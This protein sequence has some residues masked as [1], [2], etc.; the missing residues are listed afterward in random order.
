MRIATNC[1]PSRLPQLPKNY[2]VEQLKTLEL[3]D[4]LLEG[5]YDIVLF[6]YDVQG[7]Y[8]YLERLC[9]HTRRVPVIVVTKKSLTGRAQDWIHFES[10]LLAAGAAYVVP[11]TMRGVELTLRLKAAKSQ[12]LPLSGEHVF[13]EGLL[14]INALTQEVLYNDVRVRLRK[15]ERLI[16]YFLASNKG[17]V[18]TYEMLWSTFKES[19]E[20]CDER[21]VR[22]YI[23]RIRLKLKE[24]DPR[25]GNLIK[26]VRDFGYQFDD[27]ALA[28]AAA[29]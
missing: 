13:C 17:R 8:L 25:F 12:M 29:L 20:V 26:S 14:R 19:T 21:H 23:S 2:H 7:A 15:R 1:N 18:A 5:L 3:V 10:Y 16:L 27:E 28:T 4:G 22:V 11:V 9:Q 24:C 6:D